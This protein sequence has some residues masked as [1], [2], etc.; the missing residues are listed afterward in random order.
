[1]T[2][3]YLE[4]LKKNIFTFG[5][6][7]RLP[8]FDKI[9]NGVQLYATIHTTSAFLTREED[10]D[11]NKI[12]FESDLN[13]IESKMLNLNWEFEIQ[14]DLSINAIQL[15]DNFKTTIFLLNKE[16]RAEKTAIPL[17]KILTK[18]NDLAEEVLYK[19]YKECLNDF[20]FHPIS[21]FEINR[22]FKD[23][24]LVNLDTLLD[25]KVELEA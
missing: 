23:T 19:E 2:Q 25:F 15:E 4:T 3:L 10:I 8:Q 9:E 7:M 16:F 6:Y 18:F 11:V 20:V 24:L 12:V 22:H 13:I 1:M 17:Q 21:L 5:K 14:P